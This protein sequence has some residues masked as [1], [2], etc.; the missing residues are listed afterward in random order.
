VTGHRLDGRVAIISG[1]VGA[2]GSAAARHFVAEGAQV[3]AGDLR[4]EEGA[5][6]AK[7]LGTAG[8]FAHLDVTDPGSWRHA[9]VACKERFGPPSVLINNAGVMVVGLIESA[10]V[11][12]FERA[13]RVNVLGCVLGIQAVLA[14]M[15]ANGGGSIVNMSSATGLVGTAAL[16][17]YAASKAGN[18]MVAKCAAIELGHHGIRVNSV[19][20]GGIDTPMSNS[21]EFDA[22]DKDAWYGSM[23]IPRIGRPEDI[24]PLLVYLA[25]NESS[26][27][28]GTAFIAD[29]GMLA[30]PKVM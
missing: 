6:L 14:E 29:G 11:E 22:M 18:E 21:P 2:I 27:C 26:F 23:P 16:S 12:Q 10:P 17:A 20:P 4:D 30:G 24:A 19:H 15:Q 3:L 9:V 5:V 8:A 1:G 7:E 28:T 13:F 25:S